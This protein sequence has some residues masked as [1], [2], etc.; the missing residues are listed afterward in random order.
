MEASPLSSD[1]A[2][3]LEQGRIDFDTGR[4]W[5]AHEAWEDLWNSLKRRNADKSEVLLVQG[6]IQTAAL[7]YNHQRQKSRGVTNQWEKLI[8]KLSSWKTAWGFDIEQH[9][10]NISIYVED[11]GIWQQTYENMSLPVANEASK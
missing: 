10:E 2:V 11:V 7:L 1:E 4:Y 8:P 6:L 9:V 5:H 3:L